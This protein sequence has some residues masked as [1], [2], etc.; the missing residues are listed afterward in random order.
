M[1]SNECQKELVNCDNREE[2]PD[3]GRVLSAPAV[4]ISPNDTKP[5]IPETSVESVRIHGSNLVNAQGY[6]GAVLKAK[7][8]FFGSSCGLW[9]V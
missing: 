5:L 7:F 4:H 6:L 2:L 1:M 3:S 8:C 9:P